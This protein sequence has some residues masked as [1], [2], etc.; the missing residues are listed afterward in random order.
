MMDTPQA[1]LPPKATDNFFIQEYFDWPPRRT[2]S[3]KVALVNKVLKKLGFWHQLTAPPKK[4]GMTNVE[5]RMNMYHLVSQVLAY[6]VEGDLVE[7]GC[8]KGESSV[9]IQKVIDDYAPER[10]LFVYDS[11]EGLPSKT[12]NDGETRFQEGW[13]RTNEEV[14]IRNF[15]AYGLRKPSIC[16]GWFHETLPSQLPSKICF[17]YLDGDFYDSIMV[18]LQHVYPRL[19]PGAICLIDDYADP[20]VGVDVWNDLP[21]VKR[22]CDEYLEDKP[23]RMCFIYSGYDAS[24]G[25]FRKL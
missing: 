21:G 3:K 23:E 19:S 12:E 20:S 8:N 17:A 18:S 6:G 14:L 25:F 13:C 2:T 22:A 16:K 7:L 9:L 10:R 5:Q 24:H 15:E 1:K 11:F 4:V